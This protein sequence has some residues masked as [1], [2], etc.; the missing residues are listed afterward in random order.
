M[1][2]PVEKSELP[3]GSVLEAEADAGL[4]FGVEPLPKGA[5]PG[6]FHEIWSYSLLAA[7]R[8]LATLEQPEQIRTR[9]KTFAVDSLGVINEIAAELFPFHSGTSYT[10]SEIR[11]YLAGL[12][13]WTKH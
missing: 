3:I 12:N 7:I 9:Q 11:T 13:G 4:R 1:L 8:A 10:R 2:R 6:S 5:A